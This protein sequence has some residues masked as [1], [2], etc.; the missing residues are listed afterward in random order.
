MGVELD[1]DVAW[2]AL[3]APHR[4]DGEALFTLVTI[5]IGADVETPVCE[6][7][8]LPTLDPPVI[9]SVGEI[10]E[11][12]S[13]L[14]GSGWVPGCTGAGGQQECEGCGGSEHESVRGDLGQ[15]CA[16]AL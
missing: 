7:D 4:G 11:E 12:Q 13:V 15:A 3:T 14:T 2:K 1:E 5:G 9:Q 10:L 8:S 16:L 6:P